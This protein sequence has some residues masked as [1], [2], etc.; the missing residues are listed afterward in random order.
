MKKL[1][2]KT[3]AE[4]NLSLQSQ[5][6]EQTLRIDNLTRIIRDGVKTRGEVKQKDAESNCEYMSVFDA[7]E[8]IKP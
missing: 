6:D 1:T 4:D 8:Q 3:L 2:M 7:C 5:L